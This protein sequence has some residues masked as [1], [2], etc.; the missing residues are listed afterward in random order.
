MSIKK[1]SSTRRWTGLIERAHSI[2][3][4][5]ET[6]MRILSEPHR[7]HALLIA[8][9]NQNLNSEILKFMQPFSKLFEVLQLNSK[10]TINFVVLTYYKAAE[11]AKRCPM[12]NPVIATLKKEFLIV[13]N[14]SF[15]KC[16]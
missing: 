4:S 15:L 7:D 13:L 10:P 2:N 9:V 14:Q 5:Y 1:G 6:L 11:L 8:L 16:H 3:V 12:D